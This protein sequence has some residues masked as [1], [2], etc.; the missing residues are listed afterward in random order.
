M[1]SDWTLVTGAGG[2]LG[3]RLVRELVESGKRVKAL[4]RAGG[5]MSELKD[6]PTDRVRI[7]IGDCRYQDRVYAALRSCD[8][9]YHVAA[10]YSIDESKRRAILD[11]SIVATEA[12][13]EAARR[14]GVDKIVFTSSVATLGSSAGPE[15]LDEGSFL[16]PAGATSYA[17]AKLKAEAIAL[18]RA[19]EGLPVVVVNPGALFGPG[20][21]KPTPSGALVLSYLN[22]SPSFKIPVMP[23]GFSLV[24]VD[25]VAQGHIQ[26]MEKGKIGERYILAS[27]NCDFR[28]FYQMLSD[29][30]GLSEP[31]QELSR[32]QASWVARFEELKAWWAGSSPALT[33]KLV[34]NHYGRYLFV[35]SDKAKRELGFSPR[36]A[37]E[38]LLRACHYFLDHGF[39]DK[40]AAR[41]ARLELTSMSGA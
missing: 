8:S 31:G 26:A 29:I 34:D 16:E 13:L 32:S 4:V 28:A 20:D 39:V 18:E 14:A 11:D 27:E 3:A 12:T 10:T 5:D 41:R 21:F 1:S 37:R 7:A 6:L 15:P 19:R 33:R 38:A 23:G 36:P 2:F 22:L 40:R 9:M 30:S 24:D 17:E 35:S 25:D